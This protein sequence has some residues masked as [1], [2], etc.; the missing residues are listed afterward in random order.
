MITVV[1]GSTAALIYAK[2]LSAD[3]NHNQL[4]AVTLMSTDVDRIGMSATIL[5]E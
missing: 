1:R 2:A 4:A 5:G 3:A